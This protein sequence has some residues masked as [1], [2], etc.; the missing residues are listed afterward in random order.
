M[1]MRF[2]ICVDVYHRFRPA[3]VVDIDAQD[4]DNEL[5][6]VEYVEDIYKFYKLVEVQIWAPEVNDFVQISD[7]AYEHR[8]VLVMEKRIL[9]RLEWNLTLPTLYVFLTRLPDDRDF[10]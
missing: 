10:V 4:M 6:E 2:S 5:A 7:R 8:H 9:G 1:K 3:N